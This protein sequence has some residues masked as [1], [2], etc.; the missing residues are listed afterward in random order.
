MNVKSFF[1]KI[2]SPSIINK[3]L[4]LPKFKAYITPL[5][6]DAMNVS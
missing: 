2:I 5:G 3:H 1:I 4:L 6:Y